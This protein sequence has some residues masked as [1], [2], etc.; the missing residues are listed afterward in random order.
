MVFVAFNLLFCVLHFRSQQSFN[1]KPVTIRESRTWQFLKTPHFFSDIFVSVFY[2]IPAFFKFSL[3]TKSTHNYNIVKAREDCLYGHLTNNIIWWTEFIM[4]IIL[5]Q[6]CFFPPI[7][8]SEKGQIFWD[9]LLFLW[10]DK[11]IQV[12][13][14]SSTSK[15]SFHNTSS[16]VRGRERK[17]ERERE[18]TDWLPAQRVLEGHQSET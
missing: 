11:V 18:S 8:L 5:K 1:T 15:N 10:D 7:D 12:N 2:P 17:R 16:V 6:V 3:S 14:E 13:S 9:N 4:L